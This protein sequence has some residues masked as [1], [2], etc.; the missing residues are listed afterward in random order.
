MFFAG[1]YSHAASKRVALPRAGT[2][3]DLFA[4]ETNTP[5]VAD[6]GQIAVARRAVDVVTERFGVPRYARVD[7]VRDDQGDPCVLELEL[8]EPSFFL[9]QAP[10]GAVERLVAALRSE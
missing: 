5:Y 2:V 7:L 6:A 1:R 3:D 9:P 4:A 10:P 8:I